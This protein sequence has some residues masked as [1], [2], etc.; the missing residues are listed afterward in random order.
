MKIKLFLTIQCPF[1]H[2]GMRQLFFQSKW[3]TQMENTYVTWRRMFPQRLFCPVDG[4]MVLRVYGQRPLAVY[5]TTTVKKGCCCPHLLAHHLHLVLWNEVSEICENKKKCNLSAAA[6]TF[7]KTSFCISL[8]FSLGTLSFNIFT[9]LFL[10]FLTYFIQFSFQQ[11]FNCLRVSY[12][13]AVYV[14]SLL[15]CYQGL[16]VRYDTCEQISD[17]YLQLRPLI[18]KSNTLVLLLQDRSQARI[19]CLAL[20]CYIKTTIENILQSHRYYALVI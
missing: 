13:L 18:T 4:R 11:C 19:A 20:I 2:I 7:F 6:T 1:L 16:L 9:F 5:A 12:T 15:Q 8:P 10:A 3:P 17:V 14:S